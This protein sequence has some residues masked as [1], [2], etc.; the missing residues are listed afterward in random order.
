MLLGV[1]PC[2]HYRGYPLPVLVTYGCQ[3]NR[4]HTFQEPQDIY[5]GTGAEVFSGGI[6]DEWF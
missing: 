4:S 3:A 1:V 5:T 6:V 2:E